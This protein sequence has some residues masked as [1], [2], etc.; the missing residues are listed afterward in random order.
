MDT[1]QLQ[2]FLSLSKTLNFTKTA[3]EFYVKIFYL[4]QI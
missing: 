3:N 4:G 2:L 1:M